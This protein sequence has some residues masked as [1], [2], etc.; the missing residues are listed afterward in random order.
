MNSKKDSKRPK[1]KTECKDFFTQKNFTP[2]SRR[3]IYLELTLT[4]SISATCLLFVHFMEVAILLITFT[5]AMLACSSSKL[6]LTVFPGKPIWTKSVKASSLSQGSLI[7]IRGMM[8][9]IKAKMVSRKLQI[10]NSQ[11]LKSVRTILLRNK[12]STKFLRS[13]KR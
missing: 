9:L 2:L 3:K 1:T 8:I 4:N 12:K 11:G 5:S 7:L 10:P 6:R 13:L